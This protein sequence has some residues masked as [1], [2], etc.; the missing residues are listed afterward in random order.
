MQSI[1]RE[2]G[3]SG[4]RPFDA[5]G[6]GLPSAWATP[7]ENDEHQGKARK[8]AR[9]TRRTRTKA[10]VGDV[11]AAHAGKSCRRRR[12]ERGFGLGFAPWNGNYEA[13]GGG[14]GVEVVEENLVSGRS[15]LCGEC[16]PEWR[17][18]ERL[19]IRV[20]GP[21]QHS[22]LVFF[23]RSASVWSGRAARS[24][25]VLNE[26]RY[27]LGPRVPLRAQGSEFGRFLCG[28]RTFQSPV[29]WPSVRTIP[30]PKRSR[31]TSTSRPR[32]GCRSPRYCRQA[33]LRPHRRRSVARPV[34]RRK[35]GPFRMRYP[36]PRGTWAPASSSLW[37][38]SP[39]MERVWRSSP[40]RFARRPRWPYHRAPKT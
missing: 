39:E 35:R 25:V 33:P 24:R 38:R 14:H 26:E 6:A 17:A 21:S 8:E 31:P 28:P 18:I 27:G 15:C 20:F 1:S 30:C 40:W 22:Q 13:S 4:V 32:G 12:A 3:N 37:R 9:R 5:P 36:E 29:R 19:A 10:A 16:E 2:R 34:F 7:P 11:S 23:G